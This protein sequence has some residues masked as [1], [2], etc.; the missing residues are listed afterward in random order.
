MNNKDCAIAHIDL[1]S[2][3]AS[4]ECLCNPEIRHLPVAVGGDQES[5]HGI[6]LAKNQIA[7]GF[8]IKTGETV[9]SAMQKCSNLVLVRG[10]FEKYIK[11]SKMVREIYKEYTDKIEPFGID[12]AWLDLSASINIFG[13][14]VKIV[15]EI[16]ERIYK[17]IG[18]TASAGISYNKVFA[19]L[20]SDQR[21]PY[22]LFVVTRQ[23]YKEKIWNLPVSDLLY[24]G[25][26]TLKKLTL[27]NIH[28]IAELANADSKVLRAHFGKNGEMLKIFANGEDTTPVSKFT[29]ERFVKSIGNSL[30]LP[31]DISTNDE[32]YAV[33]CMISESVAARL[34]KHGLKATGIQ[35][36]VRD[37]NL[38]TYQMQGK[39]QFSTCISSEIAKK[40]YEI[41]LSKYHSTIPTRSVGIKCINLDDEDKKK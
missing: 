20:G 23:N 41:Y 33:F 24:V 18:I 34:R 26:A 22:G 29:D 38:Q 19:K 35:I 36:S 12:E 32:M 4:V 14:P 9:Y 27:L 30:T 7:K 17:E 25:R 37:K 3:Y 1:D 8:N 39:L 15:E 28:T 13:P 2:F 31:R 10:D 40:A 21:K 5:R 6:I 16:Q 11:Y